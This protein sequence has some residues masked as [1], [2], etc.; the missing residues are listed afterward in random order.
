M[1]LLFID[2]FWWSLILFYCIFF[3]PNDDHSD[4]LASECSLLSEM[5]QDWLT[6]TWWIQCHHKCFNQLWMWFGWSDTEVVW[7][8]LHL[9][10]ALW[11]DYLRQILKA[12]QNQAKDPNATQI[13]C[14]TS[15]CSLVECQSKTMLCKFYF[16]WLTVLFL[17]SP[18]KR[19]S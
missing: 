9:Y 10:L 7:T 16:D 12:D 18:H 8:C 13:R 15:E 5:H 6:C 3:S 17:P 2:I 14:Q 4:W 11:S 19:C 1:Y